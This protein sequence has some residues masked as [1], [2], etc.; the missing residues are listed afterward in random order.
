MQ[1]GPVQI[2]EAA[3][4]STVTPLGRTGVGRAGAV[5]WNMPG[6]RCGTWSLTAETSSA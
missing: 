6:V 2:F 1:S 5:P 3:T 4:A